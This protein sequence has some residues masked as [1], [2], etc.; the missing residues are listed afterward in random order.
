MGQQRA[1]LTSPERSTLCSKVKGASYVGC[2][3]PSLGARLNTVGVHV[4]RS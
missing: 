3:C 4:G 2:M 1:P